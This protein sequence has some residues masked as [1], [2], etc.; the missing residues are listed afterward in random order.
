MLLLLRELIENTIVPKHQKIS[1]SEHT[2][3]VELLVAKDNELK[4][5]LQLASEQAKIEQ[6]M[7]ALRAQ[8]DLHVSFIN[9]SL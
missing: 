7:N 9:I 4:S 8:V 2:A 3:L 5:V 1:S 6:K